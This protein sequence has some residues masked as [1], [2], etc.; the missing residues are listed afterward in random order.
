MAPGRYPMG[1]RVG[2]GAWAF[3]AMIHLCSLVIPC[4]VAHRACQAGKSRLWNG[5]QRSS[6]TAMPQNLGVVLCTGRRSKVSQ[7]EERRLI[8]MW[9]P[10]ACK[11]AS[12]EHVACLEGVPKQH[13]NPWHNTRGGGGATPPSHWR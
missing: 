13:G 4:T 11:S 8:A 3:I 6:R 1:H 12:A 2:P 7:V 5:E 9:Q 10:M